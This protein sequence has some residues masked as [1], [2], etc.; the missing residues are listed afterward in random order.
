MSRFPMFTHLDDVLDAAPGEDRLL[1]AL[2]AAIDLCDSG[3]P[4]LVGRT[5][6]LYPTFA[7]YGLPWGIEEGVVV[8]RDSTP[9]GIAVPL[10]LQPFDRS[11]F[12]DWRLTPVQLARVTAA[13]EL[14][15]F[16]DA[17]APWT[18]K[19]HVAA[20]VPRLRAFRDAVREA[21]S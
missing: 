12:V 10:Y 13:R 8:N 4:F 16:D 17:M 18:S 15:L 19:A 6:A 9:V 14:P 5:D 20:Y 21:R 7:R 11:V 3:A 1:R 2:N